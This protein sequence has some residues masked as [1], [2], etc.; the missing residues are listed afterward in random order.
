MLKFSDYLDKVGPDDLPFITEVY[1][2][3]FKTFL[4][5]GG[6]SA[7]I[8][9]NSEIPFLLALANKKSHDESFGMPRENF[10]KYFD[11]TKIND[12]K[13]TMDKIENKLFNAIKPLYKYATFNK[14]YVLADT[15]FIPKI[16][17]DMGTFPD[18]FGW[19]G[20][21]ARKGKGK[22]PS[23]I[24]FFSSD[25]LGISVKAYSTGI[26]LSNLKPET[27]MGFDKKGDALDVMNQYSMFKH[28][29]K[30]VNLFVLAKKKVF[31]RVIN[32]AIREKGKWLVPVKPKYKIRYISKDKEFEIVYDKITVRKKKNEI[33]SDNVLKKAHKWMRV[34]GDWF[35]QNKGS[36]DLQKLYQGMAEVS[37]T[38]ILEAIKSTLS[39]SSAILDVLNMNPIKHYY[40]TTDTYIY[41]V[42]SG[43]ML[44]DELEIKSVDFKKSSG[45]SGLFFS[46]EIGLKKHDDGL[47]CILEIRYGQG[48]FSTA[49]DARVTQVK[50]AEKILWVKL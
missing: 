14:Y 45:V 30:S 26:T 17:A 36:K 22:N 16:K 42:P 27:L 24:D 23:D 28:K 21:D 4:A 39:S 3:E 9:M 6:S 34:F 7:F 15:L 25:A 35:Q 8:K 11:S 20:D 31:I 13:N 46:A 18:T 2:E 38:N 43:E 40:Y 29:D 5:E 19:I 44:H 50:E 1:T 32:A 41:M 10:E 49:Q 47:L 48:T 33:L 12:F 37:A